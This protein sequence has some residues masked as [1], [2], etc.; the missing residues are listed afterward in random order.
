VT[1]HSSR[2]MLAGFI[3]LLACCLGVAQ[4]TGQPS[5][6]ELV[7]AVIYNEVHPAN[8]NDEVHWKYRLDK[9]LDGKQETR[10]VVETKSGSLDKLLSIAGSPLNDAQQRG[11]AERIL[12]LSRDP[13]QQRKAEQARRKDAEQCNSFLQMIPNAFVFENAGQD[14]DLLKITFRPN[15]NFQAPTREGKV[16]QQMA[17]EMWVDASQKRLVS[18]DGQLVN[19]VKFAGGLLGHLEKGGQFAVKRAEL[20]NGDWEVTEINVNMH[21]KALLFKSISVQQKEIHSN[22]ERVPED[23]TLGDAANLLLQQALVAAKQ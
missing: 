7:K 13:G 16:L 19:E 11:E 17:G 20:A 9:M 4:T 15:P 3:L 2:I 10:E 22:F 12:K 18:I 21:G 23:L 14:G 1:T 8:S 5:P 6:V